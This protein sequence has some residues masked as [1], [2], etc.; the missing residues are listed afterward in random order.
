[1]DLPTYNSQTGCDN[2]Y[3]II[4]YEILEQIGEER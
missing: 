1:M 2:F 3:I 4:G